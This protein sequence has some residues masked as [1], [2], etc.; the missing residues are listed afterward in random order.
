MNGR[1]ELADLGLQSA[2]ARPIERLDRLALALVRRRRLA[3]RQTPCADGPAR[4]TD[5]ADRRLDREL[6]Q[7]AERRRSA[8][9]DQRRKVT[10]D[11]PVKGTKLG[12]G[13]LDSVPTSGPPRKPV[14]APSRLEKNQ[15]AG[16]RHAALMAR[17]S[18]TKTPSARNG[19]ARAS[20][21]AG[22]RAFAVGGAD[23]AMPCGDDG[24][25]DELARRRPASARRCAIVCADVERAGAAR[26][27]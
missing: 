4:A 18:A 11:A 17:C 16:G 15:Y 2:V 23:E 19:R 6:E 22:C 10:T 24:G 9:A 7:L 12:S 25:A 21:S 27:R 26:A 1:R 20:A 5:D 14:D 13:T 8:C 3:L